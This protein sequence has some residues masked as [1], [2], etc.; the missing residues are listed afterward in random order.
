MR[1]G[2]REAEEAAAVRGALLT[3]G[4]PSGVKDALRTKYRARE[5]S[6]AAEIAEW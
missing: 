2:E 6:F 5:K 1:H 3:D 4:G